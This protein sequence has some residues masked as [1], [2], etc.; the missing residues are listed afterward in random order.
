MKKKLLIIVILSVAI[1][2]VMFIFRLVYGYY[3]YPASS[4]GTSQ[5]EFLITQNVDESYQRSIKNIATKKYQDSSATQSFDQ[6]YE[7]IADLSSLTSNFDNDEKAVK[8]S[9]QNFEALIQD[10]QKSGLKGNRYLS[11]TIGV[12]PD[13]FDAMIES[14]SSIGKLISINI[15]KRDKTNEYRELSSKQKTLEKTRD[16][17]VELKQRNASVEDLINLETRILE[18]ENEIQALGV[19]LG[20]FDEENEFC[21]VN[22]KLSESSSSF[23][24]P[25]LQRIKVAFEW[26]VKYYLLLTF[27]FLFCVVSLFIAIKISEKLKIMEFIQQLLK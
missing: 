21:T 3:S 24:I 13:S 16:S 25:V 9:I 15:V 19:S 20:E 2:I 27:A 6:K 10:E 18:I 17:L 26:T 23:Q 8:A 5:N 12:P 1:F 4:P 22:I 14:I 7:K 11:L